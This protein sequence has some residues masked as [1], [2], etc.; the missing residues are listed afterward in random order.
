MEAAAWNSST[1]QR[2]NAEAPHPG[3]QEVPRLSDQKSLWS[4]GGVRGV[5]G[6][7]PRRPLNPPP[8]PHPSPLTPATPE[9]GVISETQLLCHT[10]SRTRTNED[11]LM[12]TL[13]VFFLFVF[14]VEGCDGGGGGVNRRGAVVREIWGTEGGERVRSTALAAAVTFKFTG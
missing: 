1:T 13:F 14:F 5:G 9:S 12:R 11:L 7:A 4:G 6:Y 3:L 10:K 2:S 8:P